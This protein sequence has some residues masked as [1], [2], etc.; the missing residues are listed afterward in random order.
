[1]RRLVA[2]VVGHRDEEL[3]LDGHGDQL[4]A[5][6]PAAAARAIRPG[7]RVTVFLDDGGAVVGWYHEPSKLGAREDRPPG[8][9]D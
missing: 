6:A 9:N 4:V 1:M 2:V 5:W 8:A 3:R 7:E